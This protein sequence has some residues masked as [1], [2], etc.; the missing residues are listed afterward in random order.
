MKLLGLA[1]NV[2]IISTAALISNMDKADAEIVYANELTKYTETI[3]KQNV[4]NDVQSINKILDYAITVPYTET[5]AYREEELRPYIVMQFYE[6]DGWAEV[7]RFI[8]IEEARKVK[9]QI[10]TRL[11][12][13]GSNEAV[14]IHVEVM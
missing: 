5:N 14:S 3:Y 10:T 8:T 9:Q 2:A 1:F 7:D 4:S 6:V 11:R 12:A 13:I